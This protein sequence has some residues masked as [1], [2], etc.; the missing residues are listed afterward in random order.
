MISLRPRITLSQSLYCQKVTEYIK[1][2][3]FEDYYK[4]L[5]NKECQN[6]MF[7]LL[8]TLDLVHSKGIMH[9]DIKPQNILLS[10]NKKNLKLIDFGLSIQYNPS[11]A[12]SQKVASRLYKAPELLMDVPFYN[13]SID[14][15]GA[16]IIFANLVK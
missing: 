12:Y 15:W 3:N 11:E 9:R 5:T 1:S 8:K 6:Y 7:Q 2:I 14:I 4:N 16:G 10:P 13:Y